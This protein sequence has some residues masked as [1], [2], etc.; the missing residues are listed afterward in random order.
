MR[1]V[2]TNEKQVHEIGRGLVQAARDVD[3]SA[4]RGLVAEM[5]PY[6]S[7]A[8]RRMSARAISRW[9]KENEGVKLSAVTIAKAL[10][11]QKQNWGKFFETIEPAARVFAEAHDEDIGNILS[12]EGYFHHLKSEVK[13]KFA[14][15]DETDGS[16]KAYEYRCASDVLEKLWFTLDVVTRGSCLAHVELE[17]LYE[18][19]KQTR[20]KKTG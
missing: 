3:F 10:R 13:L 4:Q 18:K 17:E 1:T 5:F 14:A 2:K 8:S 9:L 15:F 16:E 7:E 11:N 12:Q 6:I 19:R 20:R